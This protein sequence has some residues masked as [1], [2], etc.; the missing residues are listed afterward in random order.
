MTLN[1]TKVAG[2]APGATGTL[3]ASVWRQLEAHANGLRFGTV[4]LTFHDGQVVQ[5]ERRERIRLNRNGARE[6]PSRQDD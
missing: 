2:T 6:H 4:E 1:E 5:I 3:P